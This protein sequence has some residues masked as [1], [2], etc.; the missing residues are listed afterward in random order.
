MGNPAT[1]DATFQIAKNVERGLEA[2]TDKVQ[3][4]EINNEQK[5]QE[6]I[7]HGNVRNKEID[8]LTSS[9]VKLQIKKLELEEEN[10]RLRNLSNRNYGQPSQRSQPMQRNQP[11]QRNQLYQKRYRNV[12]HVVK[13]VII[14]EI[15]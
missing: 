1:L 5:R 7:I 13:L 6:P 10:E 15:V 11:I 4:K 8:E 14:Q 3:P 2:L 9:F 12:S